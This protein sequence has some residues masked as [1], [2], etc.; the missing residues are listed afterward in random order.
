[1]RHLQSIIKPNTYPNAL[2]ELYTHI[3]SIP[4]KEL[5]ILTNLEEKIIL[6]ILLKITNHKILSLIIISFLL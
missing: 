6:G 5:L 1:M 2:N 4:L 3:N